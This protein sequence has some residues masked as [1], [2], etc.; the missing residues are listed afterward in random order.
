MIIKNTRLKYIL[1]DILAA[2]VVW[3][4]FMVFRRAV[5]NAHFNELLRVFVPNYDFVNGIFTF[6]LVCLFVHYLTGFYLYVGNSVKINPFATTLVASLII[7]IGIFFA[8]LIDDIVV[9]YEY[10]YYSLL[11][12]FFLLFSFTYLFRLIVS[13]ILKRK[14]RVKQ[15]NLNTVIIGTGKNAQQI[16]KTLQSE[17]DEY[18]V[19]GFVAVDNNIYVERDLLLGNLQNIEQIIKDNKVSD[20]VIALE[21][22][23]EQRMFKIINQLYVHNIDIR[24]TPSLYEILTGGSKI[25][26]I[27]TLPLIDITKLNVNYWQLSVKRFIDIVV[28]F[29]SLVFLLPLF[30]FFA[31]R[32]KL[33]SKGPI[34][35]KQE[36]IGYLGRPFNIVKFRTMFVDAENGVPKLSSPD[37]DR[38]TR[39]GRV[40]R[41]YRLD[42]F[43]QFWNVLIGEMSLVGPRPERLF[44][45]RQITEHAPY[46]CL[47]YKVR[48]GLTSWGPIKIGYSDTLEKMIERLNYDIIYVENMSLLNDFK[49]LIL[50]AEVLVKGKGM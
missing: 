1:T 13:K 26:M 29:V 14:Y 25:N 45:I 8:L 42:E 32:I 20:A 49:I 43:P 18:C 37:D 5:Y 11:V 35:F 47:I 28:S 27:G 23:S 21:D 44:Y 24:F 22:Y 30:A 48:P 38:I 2:F 46:Y 10:Y 50:T 15:L 9:S 33:D 41:K 19:V 3:I 12:L 7:S 17:S 6:P 31:V 16:A 39:V 36:R 40:L 4:L 34:F